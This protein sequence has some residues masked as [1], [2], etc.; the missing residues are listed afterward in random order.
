M[1]AVEAAIVV[2]LLGG[3]VGAA[4]AYQAQVIRRA[5][6]LA[7]RAD[8]QGLRAAVELFRARHR[9]YPASL[10]ELVAQPLGMVRRPAGAG[11]SL[12]EQGQDLADP[13]GRAYAYEP[14][15]GTVRSQTPGY[16]TW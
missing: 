2:A 6:A 4:A 13:F 5:K 11:W 7:L 10:E 12:R 8:L 16:E 15:H 3:C 1:T 9:R 14:S